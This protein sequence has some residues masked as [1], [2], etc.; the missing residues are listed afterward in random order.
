M[1]DYLDYW[2]RA[3]KQQGKRNLLSDMQIL[4]VQPA[5]VTRDRHFDA[6]TL[7]FWATGKDYT[8]DDRTGVIESGSNSRDRSYSEYWTL[9]RGHEVRGTPQATPNC[10]NCGAPLQTSM[11]GVCA[12]CSQH[13]TSGEFDFVLSKIEQDDSY[14]G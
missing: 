6:V 3:Y 10:P 12:H 14:A 5:K 2:I 8:I 4:R 13:I 11:A 1:F 7:R 9:I